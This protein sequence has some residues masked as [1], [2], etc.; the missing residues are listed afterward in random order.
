MRRGTNADFDPRRNASFYARAFAFLSSLVPYDTLAAP[1]FTPAEIA[2]LSFAPLFSAL[3]DL[4]GKGLRRWSEARFDNEER[5]ALEYLYKSGPPISAIRSL[6]FSGVV[7]TS[8]NAHQASTRS[9]SSS[10]P[11]PTPL[12]L[13]TSAS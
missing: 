11:R 9:A 5:L 7:L 6:N 2:I 10:S 13:P 12:W 3:P 8:K 4:T 1:V